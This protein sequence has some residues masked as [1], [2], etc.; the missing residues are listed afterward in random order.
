MI[1]LKRRPGAMLAAGV[2]ALAV[3]GTASALPFFPSS[4]TTPGTQYEDDNIEWFIDKDGDDAISVGDEL[5]AVG[6][7]SVA[8]DILAPVSPAIPLDTA[9]DEL[10]V[11][12]RVK[13]ETGLITDSHLSLAHAHFGPVDSGTPMVAVYSMGSSIDLDL[14]TYVNCSDMTSCIAAVEDG[15]LLAEFTI[16]DPDDEWFFTPTHPAALDPATVAG[17]AQ[18]T[19]V[20]TV[21]FALSQVGGP[22]ETKPLS[23]DC[24]IFTCAGDGLTNIVGSSDILGGSGLPA[25]LGAFATSDTDVSVIPEPGA[26][27]LLGMGLLGAGLARRRRRLA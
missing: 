14:G 22:F 12:S 7:F 26:L 6:E 24:T 10:V 21:N 18:T 8:R 4:G 5:V 2:L 27:A 3:S 11:V 13:V 23:I 19:K 15:T 16:V 1:S 20:G 9:A 17:L 25:S